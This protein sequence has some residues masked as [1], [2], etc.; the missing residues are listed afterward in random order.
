MKQVSESNVVCGQND[1]SKSKTC[2]K[3][4][5]S[6]GREKSSVQKQQTVLCFASQ[7]S[8]TSVKITNKSIPKSDVGKGTGL[9][10]EK[11]TYTVES[12][13]FVG[14]NFHGLLVFYLFVGI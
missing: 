11:R 7:T 2:T 6:N 4:K 3:Q 10:E 14:A 5:C 12:F 9:Q 8:S 13:K 1:G